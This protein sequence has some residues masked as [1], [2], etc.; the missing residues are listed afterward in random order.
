[1]PTNTSGALWDMSR[2]MGP[3]GKQ[4]PGRRRAPCLGLFFAYL[5]YTTLDASLLLIHSSQLKPWSAL[6]LALV[7]IV[8]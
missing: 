7:Y 6:C 4:V 1:M 5:S 8:T 3:I 2:K